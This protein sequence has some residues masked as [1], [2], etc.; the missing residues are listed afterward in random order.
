MHCGHE[1]RSHEKG[2]QTPI[3]VSEP[4]GSMPQQPSSAADGACMISHA[5]AS[6]LGRNIAKHYWRGIKG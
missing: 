2:M 3:P 4:A 5:T 6:V 1:G